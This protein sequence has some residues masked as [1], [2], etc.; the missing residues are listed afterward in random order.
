MGMFDF[1]EVPDPNDENFI[2]ELKGEAL[3]GYLAFNEAFNNFLEGQELLEASVEWPRERIACA[4]NGFL[5]LHL[6]LYPES[7]G[8]PGSNN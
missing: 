4:K 8:I 7:F 3:E 6:A 5:M 1:N 2:M